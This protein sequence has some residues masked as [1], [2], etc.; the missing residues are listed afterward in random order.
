MDGLALESAREENENSIRLLT[1]RF[2]VVVLLSIIAEVKKALIGP[3]QQRS[4]T[5]AR[6]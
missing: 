5:G 4:K 6:A 2:V 3:E 1:M